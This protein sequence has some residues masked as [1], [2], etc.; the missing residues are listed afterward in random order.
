ML[1]GFKMYCQQVR[2]INT[3]MLCYVTVYDG[4][5]EVNTKQRWTFNPWCWVIRGGKCTHGFII[6]TLPKMLTP[7]VDHQPYC[8]VSTAGRVL[9]AAFNAVLFSISLRNNNTYKQVRS[10]WISNIWRSCGKNLRLHSTPHHTSSWWYSKW[11]HSTWWKWPLYHS[12]QNCTQMD[13]TVTN[14]NKQWNHK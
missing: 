9:P 12:L 2:I 6:G 3:C 4:K 11:W 13:V 10:K 14:T 1:E 8:M 7:L 5:P